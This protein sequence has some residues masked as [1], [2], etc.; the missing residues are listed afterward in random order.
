M[1]FN[2]QIIVQFKWMAMN[3]NM[4][5][6]PIISSKQIELDRIYE[7]AGVRGFPVNTKRIWN[8][9]SF[10]SKRFSIFEAHL[11][12]IWNAYLE[13]ARL[14]SNESILD[15]HVMRIKNAFRYTHPFRIL[16][17]HCIRISDAYL[18][19]ISIASIYSL[20]WNASETH[21]KYISEDGQITFH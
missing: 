19:R 4:N 1:T 15:A 6:F 21:F 10:A 8:V 20:Y 13:I 16:N 5:K 14:G 9:S 7:G 12:C 17:A 18:M 11:K 3:S 2:S